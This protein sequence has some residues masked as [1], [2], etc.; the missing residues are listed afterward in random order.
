MWVVGGGGEGYIPR[1][2]PPAQAEVGGQF[3]ENISPLT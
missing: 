3:L 1:I 2:I